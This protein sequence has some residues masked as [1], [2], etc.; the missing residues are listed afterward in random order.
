MYL[1]YYIIQ[2]SYAMSLINILLPFTST[3]VYHHVLLLCIRRFDCTRPPGISLQG[4]RYPYKLIPVDDLVR[5]SCN[6]FG[7]P[8]IERFTTKTLWPTLRLR[9][10]GLPPST[11]CPS[12]E[13][14]SECGRRWRRS[15][16]HIVCRRGVCHLPLP[17]DNE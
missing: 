9:S 6:T 17:G 14:Q 13:D 16:N 8:H 10:S 11:A 4:N 3:S 5:G 1:L 12:F 2:Y 15:P 7:I